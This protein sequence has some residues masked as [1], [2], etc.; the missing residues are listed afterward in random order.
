MALDVMLL[1]ADFFTGTPKEIVL[2]TPEGQPQSA[3]ALLAVLNQTFIPNHVLVVGTE[4]DFSGELGT[5]VPW[6]KGKPAKNGQATAYVCER[7]AC[8]LPTNSPRVF[9]KQLAPPKSARRQK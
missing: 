3:D 7:G 4:Q 5:L 8:E 1:G 9:R 6:A 2:V